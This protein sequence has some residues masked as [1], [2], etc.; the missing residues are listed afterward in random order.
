[1]V[2]LTKSLAFEAARFR[3]RVNAVSP[4]MVE[5]DMTAMLPEAT[6]QSLPIPLGRFARPQEVA[7]V[8]AF[9]LSDAASYITGEVIHVN[10]GLG[11]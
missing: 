4:G 7:S 1:M 9:L 8:V 2:S 6:R 5:T 11:M 3:I 10:G